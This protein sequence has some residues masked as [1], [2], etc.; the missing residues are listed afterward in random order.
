MTSEERKQK[1]YENRQKKRKQKAEEICGKTFEDVFTYENM[2]DA[3]KS[4]CT[5]VRWKTSTINF[6]TMLLTQADTLQE[7]ILNDEYRFQGFKHFKTIE[8]G[9]ERDINAL[10]IHD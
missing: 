5:G 8:H 2:V 3:S 1:R 9:K 6:E 10:D 4:C 7:R